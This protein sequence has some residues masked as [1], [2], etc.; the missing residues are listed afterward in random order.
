LAADHARIDDTARRECADETGDAYL[1]EIGIDLH[2]GEN[3][4]VRMHGIG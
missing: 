1:T 3:G 2:L 4:A